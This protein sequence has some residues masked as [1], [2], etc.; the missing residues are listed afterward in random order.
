MATCHAAN[1]LKSRRSSPEGVKLLETWI[2]GYLSAFNAWNGQL[3]QWNDEKKEKLKESPSWKKFMGELSDITSAE[4]AE[5]IFSYVDIYCRENKQA[6]ISF[7]V[8]DTVMKIVMKLQ[9]QAMKGGDEEFQKL[10]N[11]LTN[12]EIQKK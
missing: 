3:D 12:K 1:G 6:P 8:D 10:I 5:N 11:D 4:S 9:E 7:A 2:A